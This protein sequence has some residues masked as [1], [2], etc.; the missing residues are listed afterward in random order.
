M[1]DRTNASTSQPPGD[2]PVVIVGTGFSGLAV[3]TLLR[4]AGISSFVILEKAADV[5]GTWRDNH[6]PGA[7]CD[8]PSHLYSYSFAPRPDWTRAFSPQREIQGYI[9]G[10]AERF[11]LMAHIRFGH[12]V[13]G[14]SFDEGDGA[15]TV[16]V[17]GRPSLR[18]RAL[19]LANGALSTPQLPDIPG[20]SDFEGEQF[21]SARWNHAYDLRGKRVAVIGTGASAIQFVPE[22]QPL[23]G[24]LDLYQRT[25]PWIL[26]KPDRAMRASEMRLF[27]ALPALQRLYRS[28]IYWTMEARALAFVYEPRLMR[29]GE[30]A[31][32]RHLAA[33]V[34]D[35]A[36]R[37]RLTPRYTMG[38]K[39]ILMSNDWYE[40]ITRPNVEVV[41][42]GIERVTARGLRTRDGRE[43]EVDAIIL[44]TGFATTSYLAALDVR[45][46]DGRTLDETLAARPETYLGISV[47]GFPNLFLM[48]GPNTGL[49]HNSMVF[50]IE[51]Q[52]RYAVQAIEA[53][54]DR[55]LASLDV[56]PDV[57]HR[58]NEA[59]QR[60]LAG[61]VWNSGCNSWYLKDGYNAAAWPGFTF[62]YWLRT[63]RLALGDYEARTFA[64]AARGRGPWPRA[65]ELREGA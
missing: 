33:R 45:G 51:A 49:G 35:P 62:E 6:Y 46:R 56:R 20:L 48:M 53:L 32:R 47:H 3:G 21:H 31:S 4:R 5:G 24:R 23:V 25:P 61:T 22:I 44:G 30:W 27:R 38:C 58:F 37:E 9:R 40:T 50:M 1:S 28:S 2:L 15:W 14:A 54:R 26:P 34:K 42:D 59:I 17:K 7:A 63:R 13:E 43:R 19:V 11:G 57:Q 16:R 41:S 60:R 10:C 18:A 36:L 65:T 39:R 29:L 64:S 8:V 12:E 52:A 55:A